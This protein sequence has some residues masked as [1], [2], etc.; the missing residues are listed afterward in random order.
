MRAGRHARS[1]DDGW[2]PQPSR[3]Q[4]RAEA[5]AEAGKPPPGKKDRRRHCK[6][7]QGPHEWIVTTSAW[8]VRRI[9][10]CSWS[11]YYRDATTWWRCRHQESCAGC[12]KILYRHV[13]PLQCPDY[14]EIT[15]G[16]RTILDQEI[17]AQQARRARWKRRPVITGRQGYRKKET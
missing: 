7:L 5:A 16:E 14:H 4:E 3:S 2:G 1:K 11:V 9:K 8:E 12:G 6:A 13:T 15:V 17:A 10:E